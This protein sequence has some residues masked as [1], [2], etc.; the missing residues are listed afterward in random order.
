MCMALSLYDHNNLLHSNKKLK[1][2]HFEG[3]GQK[4]PEWP[5]RRVEIEASGSWKVNLE[6]SGTLSSIEKEKSEIQGKIKSYQLN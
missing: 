1:H 6:E 4:K 3:F 2:H 5:Y